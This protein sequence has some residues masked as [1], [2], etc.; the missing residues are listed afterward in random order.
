MRGS[1]R[2]VYDNAI[3]DDDERLS[4][5]TLFGEPPILGVPCFQRNPVFLR[6]LNAIR[7]SRWNTFAKSTLDFSGIIHGSV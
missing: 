6:V 4:V 7:F 5:D 1:G 3:V 2:I